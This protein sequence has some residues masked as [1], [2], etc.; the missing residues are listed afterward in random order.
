LPPRAL[1]PHPALQLHRT[2]LRRDPPPGQGHRPAARRAQLPV[3]GLGG[4]RPDLARL[5]RVHHDPRRAPPPTGLA[6]T[7]A[8][9]TRPAATTRATRCRTT[10]NCR[11]RRLTCPPRRN[12]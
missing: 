10:R 4:A 2:H 3:P 6:P 9:L 5:A 12:P 11:C 1:D 8:P 7:A